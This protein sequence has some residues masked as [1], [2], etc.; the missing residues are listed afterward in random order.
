MCSAL[1]CFCFIVLPFFPN[2]PS[3][4]SWLFFFPLFRS[5]RFEDKIELETMSQPFFS[6]SCSAGAEPDHTLTRWM[7][8]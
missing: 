5:M 2:P 3:T 4:I 7:A 8:G 1:S 6:S